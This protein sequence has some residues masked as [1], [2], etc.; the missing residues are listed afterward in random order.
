MAYPNQQYLYYDHHLS[1]QYQGPS[2]VDL[3]QGIYCPEVSPVYAPDSISPPPEYAWSRG[4]LETAKP[5]PKK[6]KKTVIFEPTCTVRIPHCDE[7]PTAEDKSRLYYSRHELKMMNLE[8]NA[9]CILSRALPAIESSGTHLDR[10]DSFIEKSSAI[11]T[12][13]DTLRSAFVRQKSPPAGD[14]MF[15][16]KREN[17]EFPMPTLFFRQQEIHHST[18][19]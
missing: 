17:L 16:I 1:P 4:V 12:D 5:A 6:E 3:Y 15:E 11:A 2:N 8:A 7:C 14:S 9:L 10:R 18:L 13:K 19:V